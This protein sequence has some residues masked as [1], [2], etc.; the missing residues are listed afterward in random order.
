MILQ[1]LPGK[2]WSMVKLTA[3][4]RIENQLIQSINI[5]Q[6]S[7][8]SYIEATGKLG[9]W[10]TKIIDQF[11]LKGELIKTIVSSLK[12]EAYRY[13]RYILRYFLP[14]LPDL[15]GDPNNHKYC[16]QA[17]KNVIK[18]DDRLIKDKVQDFLESCP[19][20]WR[21]M[22]QNEFEDWTDPEH[23]EFYLPDGSPFLGKVPYQTL[24][25]PS[26]EEDIPF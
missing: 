9:T 26:N 14:Y 7:M 24:E 4:M 3:R 19:D 18:Y 5:G 16:V 17:M 20:N 15:L 8:N 12:P 11:T 23:P 6:S 13:N 21:R 2:Y 1:I 25:E 10:A 22:I